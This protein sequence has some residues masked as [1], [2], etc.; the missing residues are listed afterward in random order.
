MGERGSAERTILVV[1]RDEGLRELLG[2]HLSNAGYRVLAA[3]DALAAVRLVLRNPPDLILADVNM[4]YLDGL[5]FLAA[6]RDDGLT[7]NVPVV[8]LTDGDRLAER[9]LARGAQ[10]YLTKPIL[11]RRLLEVVAEQLDR[12][13]PPP[14]AGRPGAPRGRSAA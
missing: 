8:F 4:R 14:G 12:S 10:A 1:E 2:L 7:R 3:A 9:A 6:V 13:L 5:E 11:A